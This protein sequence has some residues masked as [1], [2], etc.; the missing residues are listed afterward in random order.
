M[1]GAPSDYLEKSKKLL[2]IKLDDDLIKDYLE[3]NAS[4]DII[5]RNSGKINV[6]YV[7]KAGERRRGEVDD[8]L[9]ID[10]IYFRNVAEI[11][12]K[13]SETVQTQCE[14]AYC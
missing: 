5:V 7:E 9:I 13:L 6:T 2:S 8:E 10:Q 1:F 11:L 4:G 12:K 3:I 14:E